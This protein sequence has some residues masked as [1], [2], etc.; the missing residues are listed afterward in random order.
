[1]WTKY[2]DFKGG[3]QLGQKEEGVRAKKEEDLRSEGHTLRY[4]EKA[5]PA[6]T[7][8]DLTMTVMFFPVMGGTAFLQS[9]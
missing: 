9:R 5:C 1:M 7:L 3:I 8:S 4:L 6:A 2:Q